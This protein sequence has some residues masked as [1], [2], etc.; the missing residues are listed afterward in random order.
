MKYVCQYSL[1]CE[2]IDE[3]GVRI[4]LYLITM[5][6]ENYKHEKHHLH[7]LFTVTFQI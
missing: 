7:Q 6:Y 1:V 4:Y 2:F 3:N 5:L